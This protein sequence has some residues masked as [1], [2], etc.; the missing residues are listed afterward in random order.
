MHLK[1]T[2]EQE[3][4]AYMDGLKDPSHDWSHILRVRKLALAIAQH[5]I[6]SGQQVDLELVEMG[7]LMH[8][9]GDAKYAQAEGEAES[10]IRHLLTDHWPEER[11][12]M[13]LQIIDNVS[14]SKECKRPC[15]MDGREWACVQDADRLDAIGAM[16][17]ARCLI[18][19]GCRN[20]SIVT[21]LEHFEEKLFKLKGMLK[22]TKGRALADERHRFMLQFYHQ[23]HSEL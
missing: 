18:F 6:E 23:I 22:T 5:E 3:V 19:G 1:L 20:R 4:K 12:I 9:L 16:G 13:L 8:D 15:V 10:L 14:Y 11:I 17:A 21:S 7:A 2:V